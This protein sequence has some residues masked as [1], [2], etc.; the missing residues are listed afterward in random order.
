MN[1]YS[2][3]ITVVLVALYKY[4]NLAIRGLHSVLENI[5]G[6]EPHSI[7]LKN[8]FTNAIRPPTATEEGLFKEKIAD[9]NPS[10]V[11][12]S[13]YSP[14][15]STAKRLTKM[16]KEN[17]SASV[18]WGG[19]HPTIMP[20]A[21]IKEAD[22]ICLGEGEGAITDL[23]TSIRDEKA[24]HQIPNLW[25]NKNGNIVKNPLRLLI[26]NFDSIPFAAYAKDSFYFIGSNT[27]TSK[28][29]ALSFPLLDI[30]PARGCP[31][32]CSYCV[33]SL[34]RPMFKDLGRFVRRRSVSNVIAEL[35][36]ILAIPGNKKR[37]V[38]FQ[39]ENFGT[40]EAWLSEFEALYPK[41]VGL[42]FKVQYNPTLINPSVIARLK[43]CGLHRLKFGLEAGTDHIRNKVFTRPGKNKE[44]IKI[45]NEIARQKVKIRYD[46]IMDI[47]WDTEESLKESIG[48][49]LQLPKPLN[50]NIYSLQYFP[51]YPLTQ[52]ALEEGHINEGDVTLD[53]LR[54]RMASSWG[55]APKVFPLTLRQILQNIIWLIVYQHTGDTI[56]KRAVFSGSWRSK[57]DL[58][59]LNLKAI[60]W[61]KHHEL[62]RRLNKKIA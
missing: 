23:V 55:F 40:Q 6:I 24:Y 31:F 51:G 60:F 57:L 49:L 36:E 13:V 27:L 2:E 4:Q 43:K 34:L 61:G 22:M 10:L 48:F 28:D 16:I 8:H 3:P 25:V 21:S 41:E 38:E 32:Q 20:E 62:K 44:M 18:V 42:P 53:R 14:Y 7:F 12:L 46:L 26:Q 29:P 50:F 9:L 1:R 33:N 56:V 15:V 47:P 17:S 37:I 54:E 35:K 58:I 11:G 5:E 52:K 19:I 45:A 39:D 59:Y 30:M